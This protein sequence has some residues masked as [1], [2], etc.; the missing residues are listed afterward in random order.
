MEDSIIIIFNR[1]KSPNYLIPHHPDPLPSQIRPWLNTPIPSSF[2]VLYTYRTPSTLVET[3]LQI[4][5]FMQNKPNPQ[6][7][8]MAAT[9]CAA[10]TYTN[11]APRPTEKNKPNQTQSAINNYREIL[12]NLFSA[13]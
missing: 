10:K 6:N 4:E 2:S 13:L 8:E 7:R 12:F 11:I 1:P 3:P 5:L 9:S